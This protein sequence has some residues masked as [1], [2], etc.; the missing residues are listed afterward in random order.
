MVGHFDLY[1]LR[2]YKDPVAA[3]TALQTPSLA[4]AVAANAHHSDVECLALSKNLKLADMPMDCA[5]YVGDD[6]AAAAA[7]ATTTA[8]AAGPRHLHARHDCAPADVPPLLLHLH[9]YYLTHLGLFQVHEPSQRSQKGVGRRQPPRRAAV[10]APPPPA[11]VH[12]C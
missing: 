5:T 10:Q 7:P 2:G 1:K 6:A 11:H 3:E 12:G 4:P 9:Y 8:P